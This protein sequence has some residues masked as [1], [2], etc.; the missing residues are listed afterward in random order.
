M[1]DIGSG[2]RMNIALTY[3]YTLPIVAVALPMFQQPVLLQGDVM[4]EIQ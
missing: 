1:A 3:S 4:M 2:D